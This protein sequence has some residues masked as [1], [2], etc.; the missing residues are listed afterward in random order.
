MRKLIIFILAVTVSVILPAC[1]HDHT[2]QASTCTSPKLC[3]SCGETEG[4]ALGHSWVDA[5]CEESRFCSF[6][7]LTSGDPVGHVW[8]NATCTTPM[9]CEACDKT[10]G[11]A[12]GHTFLP[13]T[14]V[15]AEIC[16]VCEEVQGSPLGHSVDSWEIINEASC[17]E[18]GSENGLCVI[19]GEVCTQ[20]IPILEHTSGDWEV[21]TQPTLEQ[22]GTRVK[23]CTV[24]GIELETE[25]FTLTAEEIEK[26]YKNSCESISYDTLSRKPG[27]YEERQVK[28]SVYV[29]Q[30]CSEA[31]S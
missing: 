24:C 27:E 15:D 3:T 14:C 10:N 8:T 7:G 29:V 17:S 18:V 23:N 12:N 25:E 28:F 6:C 1:G 26:I 21:L 13:A 11:E 2:W 19:C 20:E 22:N 31:K 5:T 16:S 9:T 30:V 4:D